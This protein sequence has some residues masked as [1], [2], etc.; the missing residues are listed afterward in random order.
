MVASLLTCSGASVGVSISTQRRMPS[1]MAWVSK[2]LEA[3]AFCMLLGTSKSSRCHFRSGLRMFKSDVGEKQNSGAKPLA[4]L[5]MKFLSSPVGAFAR[6]DLLDHVDNTATQLGVGDAGEGAGQSEPFRCREEIGNVGWRGAFAETV[7]ARGAAR[8]ALEQE[9]DRHLQYFRDLL[10]AACANP[11]G[12]FLV[13][14]HLLERQPQCFA[15]LFLAHAK[16]DTA[17]AHTTADIFVNR[18]GRFGRHLQHSLELRGDEA[19]RN[20]A[21]LD[22]DSLW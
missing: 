6:S 20:G 8:S 14:L 16:H 10:D 22:R 12:A 19:K 9:R 13:F 15:E 2:G 18:V 5:G 4:W 3:V 1:R 21:D 17:H 7:P 11:V